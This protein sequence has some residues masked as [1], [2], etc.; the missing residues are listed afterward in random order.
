[1]LHADVG[2]G[3]CDESEI[4]FLG[5]FTSGEKAKKSPPNLLYGEYKLH[6]SLCANL[7]QNRHQ[8][9]WYW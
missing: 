2:C 8:T 1:M 9:T 4:L 3:V 5:E 7:W 6:R